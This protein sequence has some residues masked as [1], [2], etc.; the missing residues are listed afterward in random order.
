M[1]TKKQ[2]LV[3]LSAVNIL[4]IAGAAQAVSLDQLS[5]ISQEANN[6]YQQGKDIA[7][8]ADEH[9]T[10]RKG[11]QNT[12]T[13]CHNEH[14][15]RSK[16]GNVH[17]RMKFVNNS[18]KEVKIYWLNY[19]GDRVFYKSIAPHAKYVQPTYKTHPWVVT[20]QHENC[21]S[22]FVSSLPSAIAEIR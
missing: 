17:T 22:I 19:S 12:S 8:K 4:S 10:N 21:M 5:Q 20:D 3:A 6:L 15:L 11:Q 14:G 13:A 7:D 18:A 2:L 9:Q 16:K 1:Q